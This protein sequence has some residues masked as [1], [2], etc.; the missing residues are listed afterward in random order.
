MTVT[1]TSA[2]ASAST[3]P[4]VLTPTVRTNARRAVFWVTAVL[5]ALLVGV[6][7]FAVAG[8]NPAGDRLSPA[9]PAPAG[10]KAVA[11]VLRD[12]GVTVTETSSLAETQRAAARAPGGNGGTAT[13][14]IVLYDADALLDPAQLRKLSGFAS[15]VILIDP[16]FTSLS[17]LAPQVAAAGSP[18][19]ILTA[20]CDLPAVQRAESVVGGGADSGS[21]YRVVDGPADAT[22]TTVSPNGA[23][24]RCLGSGDGVYSLVRVTTGNGSVTVFGLPDSL[25]NEGIIAG[26]NAA[27]ALGLLGEN[28]DLIWYLPSIVDLTDAAPPTFAELS[29]GWVIPVATLLGLVAL[30]AA[31]WRGRRFGPLV[32]E[33]LPVVV[34]ASETMEGRAR[35]YE[36][37]SARL[38]ALDALR[39]AAVD[40]LARL[41]G[42]PRTATLDEVAAAVASVSSR[43]LPEVRGMLLDARPRN[44]ADLV[45]LS[46]ELLALERAVAVAVRPD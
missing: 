13:A 15:D 43:P 39:I 38:R 10:T 17:E 23:P 25:T 8:S 40:R 7:T 26:G 19:A 45:R 2:D 3:A 11:E 46:D 27:L 37:G 28:A 6:I 14:T 32:V 22:D 5:F 44:D 42:L 30:A 36:R 24:L 1:D 9:N 18:D 41:C 12:G 29:P 21:G 33:T 20:D 4:T 35:L 31:F 34:R 16:S